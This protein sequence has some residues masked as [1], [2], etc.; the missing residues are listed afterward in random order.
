[1]TDPKPT[2][3]RRHFLADAGKIAAASAF[4]GMAVPHVHA[5]EDHTI[6]LALIGC[7][8]RGT[9]AVGDALS[10]QDGPIRLV[11]MADAFDDRLAHSLDALTEDHSD[12]MDVPPDRRFVGLD[13]YRRAMDC[14]EPG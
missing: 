14:L 3:T 4:A 9:G 6:R 13:A 10:V 7:G 12:R 8:G 1:M 2:A 5:A 11:A